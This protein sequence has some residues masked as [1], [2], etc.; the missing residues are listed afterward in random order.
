M[1]SAEGLHV[2]KRLFIPA[3]APRCFVRRFVPHALALDGVVVF[4]ILVRRVVA[5]IAEVRREHP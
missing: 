5:R 4:L 1:R 3:I 2:E